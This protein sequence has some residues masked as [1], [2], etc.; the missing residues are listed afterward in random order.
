MATTGKT[1]RPAS[2]HGIAKIARGTP[3]K[4]VKG[5]TPTERELV[6]AVASLLAAPVKTLRIVNNCTFT[7]D[8][9]VAV[10]DTTPLTWQPL[11]GTVPAKT[12]ASPGTRE[13]DLT[14]YPAIETGLR[15]VKVQKTGNNQTPPPATAG[16]NLNYSKDATGGKGSYQVSLLIVAFSISGPTYS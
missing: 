14:T 9:F 11:T 12:G 16:T 8:I 13:Y 1:K 2:K 5:D 3:R 7:L 10:N 6:K 4:A 15:R